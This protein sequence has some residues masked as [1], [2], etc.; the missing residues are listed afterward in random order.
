MA[1]P[2]LVMV[3][4]P[5]GEIHAHNNAQSSALGQRVSTDHW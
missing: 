2:D 1:V 4:H 3:V 5:S